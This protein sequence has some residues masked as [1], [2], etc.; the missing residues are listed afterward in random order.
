MRV[1]LISTA[2]LCVASCAPPPPAAGANVAPP[3][4][5]RAGTPGA[6]VALAAPPPPVAA[7][8]PPAPA[9]PV[10]APPAAPPPPPPPPAMVAAPPAPAWFGGFFAPSSQRLSLSNFSYDPAHV[11]TV[12]TRDADCEARDG[13]VV[14]TADFLLPL[15]GTRIV[16]APAGADVCW[17]RDLAENQGRGATAPKWSPWNRAY[18]SAGRSVDTRL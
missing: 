12:V 1:L 4:P 11:E 10:T 8:L 3:L 16:A 7:P 13:G 9:A 18:L 15:N 5:Q 2:L 6:P 17:R 14:A